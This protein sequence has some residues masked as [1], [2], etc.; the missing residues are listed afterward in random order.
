MTEITLSIPDYDLA[1]WAKISYGVVWLIV[2]IILT[3]VFVRDEPL[4]EIGDRVVPFFIATMWPLLALGFAAFAP[5]WLL[6]KTA[7]IGMRKKPER[8]PFSKTVEPSR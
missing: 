8:A 2:F 6:S 5:F 1:T 3:R 4:D 7:T